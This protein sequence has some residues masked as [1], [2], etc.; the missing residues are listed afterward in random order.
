MLLARATAADVEA[1]LRVTRILE[2][3]E[4]RQFPDPDLTSENTEWFDDDDADQCQ[5]VVR[6][7]L[8]AVQG[9][10][11]FRVTFGMGVVLD[12]RNELLDPDADTLEKHPKIVAALAAQDSKEAP[13][14]G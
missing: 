8:A 10:N 2:D 12:P 4:K 11:L 7:L 1:G 3:L 6:M 9:V 13:G 14:V 5:R